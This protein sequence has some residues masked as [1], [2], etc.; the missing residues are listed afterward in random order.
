MRLWLSLLILTAAVALLV[1]VPQ[2]EKI[3]GLQPDAFAGV[4]AKA[5]IALSLAGWMLASFRGRL[6]QALNAI[7]AW[8]AIMVVLVA[9]YTY[10][11]DM[12]DAANRVLGA[13]MP[14]V[15]ITGRG[16]EV[17]VTRDSGDHFIINARVN[18][19]AARFL[20][21]T[22]ASTVVIRQEEAPAY[23]IALSGLNY[24]VAVSTANGRAQAAP[25][26]LESVSVGD[27]EMRHVEALVTRRGQLTESLLGMSFLGRLNSY[28]VEGERL[29]LRGRATPG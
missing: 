18:G 7:A 15:A 25:V 28:T 12:A 19:R 2:G 3:L 11:F 29:I 9:G 21:D 26:M 6:P 1:L 5:V 24:S 4:A 20:F 8:L 16:G 27:I 10:R 17:V 23:G 13:V 14:G 22:G